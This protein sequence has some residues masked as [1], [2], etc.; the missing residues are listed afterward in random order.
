MN[1]KPSFL[2]YL[3]STA[4][5]TVALN[6]VRF[7]VSWLVM[8]E[9]GSATAFAIIFSVSSLVE[10]YGKPV[11]SPMADYFNRLRVYRVC[12][13]LATICVGILVL[14]LVA[15][16]FSI[17]L[18]TTFLMVLSLI[19]ALRDPASA[20]LVPALVSPEQLTAAQAMRG[21]ASSV[22]RLAAPMFSGLLLAAGGT[23][24]L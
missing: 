11:M 23:T 19:A 1:I 14:V 10:V 8:K 16:P 12:V 17:P 4:L 24:S 22:V 18:L 7:G 5:G 9:T 20:G 21:T 2:F 13:A 15:L 3:V 6:C